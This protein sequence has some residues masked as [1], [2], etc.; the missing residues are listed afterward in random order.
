[1]TD[2]RRDA[3]A[4]RIFERALDL[5]PG[6]RAAWIAAQAAGDRAL[7]DRVLRLVA[8]DGIASLH[9]GGAARTLDEEPPPERVGA[10]RITGRIGGG[11]MG[12]VY[13]GE[14]AAGDF[15]HVVAIKVIKAGLLSERLV[16]RF[17]A[18]RQTLAQLT[19]PNIAQ[20]FDGGETATGSPYIVMELV[21]GLPVLQWAEAQGAGRDERLRLFVDICGAVAFAHRSLIVH[22]D[23]TPSNVLVAQGGV[24]KLI[25]FGI[26]RPADTGAAMGSASI[27][28]L[29]LTP[30]Y[31]APERMT[32]AQVTTAADVFSLGRLLEK[33]I[34]PGPRDRE[35]RAIVARAT[36]PRPEDR[37]ATAAALGDDVRAWAAGQPVAAVGA[38]RR[39]ALGKF[40]ARHRVG[41]A[42][43]LAAVVLLVG[44]LAVSIVAYG[45]AERARA[46]EAAR[47]AELRSLAGYMIFD[48][49]ERLSRVVGNAQAR[50][51]LVDRAQRY[52]GALAAAR[53]AD[54]ALRL[55]AAR[56][57]VALARVQGVPTQPNLGQTA[58]ARANLD[59]AIAMARPIPSGD[60]A[61]AAAEALALR[62]MISAH[63]DTRAADAAATLTQAAA[64]LAHVPWPDRT[65]A[66]HRARS[67]LRRA[68]L[69][70][71]VL[72][73]RPD[74]LLRLAALLEQ[75][76]GEWPVSARGG[77]Q[78]A[79]D[80][81]YAQH[82]RGLNRYF[83]DRLL[84][85][86]ALLRDAQRR[87]AAID[88]AVPND[89]LVLS[90]MA[91]NAYVGFGTASGVPGRRREEDAF[92]ATARAT[93]DRLM[94]VEPGD[95]QVIALAGSIR[96][97]ESQSLSGKGRH[98]EAIAV[99][100]EVLALY[101]AL[102]ARG[103]APARGRLVLAHVTMGN[104][105][106]R[107]G[108]RAL[109]CRS[110]AAALARID[111]LAAQ[112]S[113]LDFVASYRAGLRD[114]L[115]SCRR[116][117]PVARLAQLEG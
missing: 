65:T 25:D 2:A 81:A 77:R 73:Q 88:R 111:A 89:P 110:Y 44:A 66:W 47:F 101:G 41:V 7:H 93:V 74:D 54:P 80:R 97:A 91:Y 24:V 46:A 32:S 19:H 102:A 18:E 52:L 96:G 17:Q 48:L 49:D 28:A 60:G 14:R 1:M 67:Q 13:R 9:T 63:A 82:Y 106:Q 53:D 85:G 99:Q 23:L 107:A 56:G 70:L 21:D 30:G 79:M 114:N 57:L 50:I 38:G 29:S 20:L 84:Q 87:F 61:A 68:Q 4:L 51:G 115:A 117:A 39:Y 42:A 43:A 94:A 104:I 58:R 72:R 75:E 116:G 109:A 64:V 71:A 69:E 103:K 22:R 95:G 3:E 27:G 26:A 6:N 62:A 16:E 37:Y 112:G 83:T 36:A 59:T 33:L 113:L 11:G 108:D 98:A 15:A 35:L 10:Y 55:E 86:I 31:S 92:L 90:M 105:A 76:I 5:P 12:T 78:A 34:P 100:R 45:R 40:V 8:A